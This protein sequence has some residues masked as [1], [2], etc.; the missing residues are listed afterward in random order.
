LIVFQ[1]MSPTRSEYS[2]LSL[3][4][5]SLED[6]R[7]RTPKKPS[8]AEENKNN[9][10][11]DPISLLLEQALTRQRDKM[12]ESFSHILQHL[13]I[14]TCEYSSSSHF[15]GTS[16]FKVQVNFDIP[17]FEGQIDTE[18]LDKWLNILEGYF[19]VHNF[20]NREKITFALLQALP[21]VKHWWET[22]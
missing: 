9:G 2:K 22:Y 13:S 12:M 3:E 10:A 14:A 1:C 5:V 11:N 18:S 6:N 16:P 4:L 19:S 21:H 7:S 17:V 8:M 15:G 20:S